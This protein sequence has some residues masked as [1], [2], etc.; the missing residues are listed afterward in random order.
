MTLSCTEKLLSLVCAIVRYASIS[1]MALKLDIPI[2]IASSTLGLEILT[3][4]AAIEKHNS[5][6]KKKRKK[7]ET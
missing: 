4:T 7:H 2:G 3:I 5:I 1:T 6:I